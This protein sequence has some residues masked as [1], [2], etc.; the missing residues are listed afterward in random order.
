ML[1]ADR[2]Q[3][4]KGSEPIELPELT[5]LLLQSL[6]SRA[7]DVVSK[8]DLIKEAWSGGVASDETLAQRIKLL[9]QSIGDDGKNPR[10]IAAVRGRGYRMLCPVHAGARRKRNWRVAAAVATVLLAAAVYFGAVVDPTTSGQQVQSLAVLPFADLSSGESRQYFADGLQ[11]ELLARLSQLRGVDIVSRTSVERYRQTSVPVA[12]IATSLE[13][14]AIVEGS[15]KID[16]NH[17]RVSVQ[18]VDGDSGMH[19]W[20]DSFNRE[21]NVSNIFAIQQE[22]AEQV[23]RALEV[24]YSH[25]SPGA[26]PTDNLAAFD[27]YLL[28]RYHTFRQTPEDL[29]QAVT[30]LQNATRIDPQFAEAWATLGW[31]WSFMGTSYGTRRPS[32]VFPLAKDA[33]LK[34]LALDG[35]LGNAHSLYADILTWYDWD[36]AAA[37]HSYRR[38]MELDPLDVLGY[39]LFLSI[40]GRNDESIEL[41]ERRL[42]AHPSDVYVQVNAAWRYLTAGFYERALRAAELADGHP[43]AEAA[44]G[45][46]YLRMQKS[47]LAVDAFSRAIERH[48]RN[49]YRIANLAVAK[50]AHGETEAADVLL[51]E[52]QATG[53]YVSPSSLATV[54]FAANDVERGFEY[55]AEAVRERDRGALFLL[56]DPILAAHRERPEFQEL[57]GIVGI[58]GR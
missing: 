32:E 16:G 15:A 52:L 48:G 54:M 35:N 20:S 21:L 41:V 7:P 44:A 4:W 11:E 25:T 31:A 9:R 33:A 36:F 28:G 43:D 46:T 53:S 2:R 10:Y 19:I 47:E 29:E 40:Q 27:A 12:T 13:V 30:H 51:S 22:V 14:D 50:Y 58:D 8:D 56:A 37:E 39:A 26:L 17:V 24:E 1:D 55:L 34:A 45:F 18:L 23:A 38:A 49:P 42:S 5:Y 6:V 57:A 3:L